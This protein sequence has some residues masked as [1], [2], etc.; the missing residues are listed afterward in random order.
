MFLLSTSWW[1]SGSVVIANIVSSNAQG[2]LFL[3][4]AYRLLA[5]NDAR[6]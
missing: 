3:L 5:I 2:R 4:A 6:S 1:L